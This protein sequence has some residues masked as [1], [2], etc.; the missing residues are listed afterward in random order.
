MTM[1]LA[2][3][4]ARAQVTTD[5]RDLSGGGAMTV[6]ELS[7]EPIT[8]Q[9]DIP[10]TNTGN[11][12]HRL[13]LYLPRNPASNTLPVIVFFHGGGWMRG[14]KADGA[15]RL[16]PFV[17]TGRYAGVSAGYRLSGELIWPAQIHDA[18]AA[19]RWV[20]ANA[21]RYGLDPDAIGAWGWNAGG[22]LALML[23]LGGDVPELEGGIGPH[24]GVSSRVTAVV[25]FFGVTEL[26]A[27]VGP[28]GRPRPDAPEAK[29]IG[30]PLL[31]LVDLARAAS[32][33]E[34]VSPLDPP[35][36][37]V[38]GDRDRVV[39]YDQAVRLHAALRDEVVPSYFVTV[40]GAGHGDF[41]T[42]ADDRVKAFFD[43]YL[44]GEMV[45]VPTGPVE[46]WKP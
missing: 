43:R 37:T 11:P 31:Q 24:Q 32:P 30:G 44:R 12:R 20:H 26:L 6:E 40:R 18:K 1:A 7:R 8:F 45:E 21:S 27:L 17:R 28:R 10:Y 38:H 13:D 22:H 29:L 5:Q 36:L 23:G 15:G 14:D 2:A 33:I 34:H 35:V 9:L 42:A 19:I 16:M 25:N 46:R 3:G 4:G 41:G 39:P